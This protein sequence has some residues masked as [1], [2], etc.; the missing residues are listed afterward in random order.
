[1]I[2]PLL[3][4]LLIAPAAGAETLRIG[5]EPFYPPYTSLT[6][7][8]APQGL[9]IDLGE[10][11]CDRLRADCLWV[12]RDFDSLIPAL[13]NGE[14]DMVIAAL[15]PTSARRETVDFSQPYE[16]P[17]APSVFAGRSGFIDIDR[18]RIAVQS[19]TIHETHLRDRGRAVVPY[20]TMEEAFDAMMAGEADLVFAAKSYLEPKVFRTGRTVVIVAREALDDGGAASIAFAKGDSLRG[21][22]DTILSGMIEDGSLD[23]IRARWLPPETDL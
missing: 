21:R 12:M 17:P 8:G 7:D 20:P 1:M 22:V 13:A 10:A 4:C 23:A 11:I 2:R 15:G 6:A 3:A 5:T 9:D 14:F 16:P 19:G 18:A